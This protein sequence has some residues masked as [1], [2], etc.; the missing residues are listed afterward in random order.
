MHIVCVCVH[1]Y[2]YIYIYIH[3]YIQK[4]VISLKNLSDLAK[5]G[6][7]I[8]V[9]KSMHWEGIEGPVVVH[10]VIMGMY[11]CMCVC[12]YVCMRVCMYVCVYVCMY[13]CMCEGLHGWASC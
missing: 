6:A 12:V 10:D 5:F 1:S 7:Q 2:V 8:A 4:W 9:A 11:V 13:V 3:T